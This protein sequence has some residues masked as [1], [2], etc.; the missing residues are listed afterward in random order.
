[1]F[2]SGKRRKSFG[3]AFSYCPA[4]PGAGYTLPLTEEGERAEFYSYMMGISYGV[5]VDGEGKVLTQQ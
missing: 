5:N 2:W 1:M 3:L 4:P